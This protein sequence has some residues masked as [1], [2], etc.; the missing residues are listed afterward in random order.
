MI[1]YAAWIKK[2]LMLQVEYIYMMNFQS[3][4]GVIGSMDGL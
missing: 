4:Q 1:K 2:I 3:I